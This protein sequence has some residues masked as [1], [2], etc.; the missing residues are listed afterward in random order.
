MQKIQYFQDFIYELCQYWIKQGCIWSQPYDMPMGAGTFHPHTFFKSLGAEPWR[1]VYVQPC[2]RPV[3]G[4]YGKSPNRLQHYYQLQVLIKPAPANILDIYLKSLEHIGINLKQNDIALYEDNWKGPT[5]GAWGLGWEVRANG[6]EVTQFTYFQEFAGLEMNMIPCEITYGLERIFMYANGHRN[7]MDIPYNKHFTYGDIFLQNEFEFSKFNFQCADTQLLFK[8]FDSFEEK[9]AELCEKKLS[10]PAYDYVLQASHV[11]NLLDARGALSVTERQRFIGRVRDGAKQCAL[12]YSNEQKET[13][14]RYKNPQWVTEA[15]PTTVKDVRKDK[16][17]SKKMDSIVDILLEIGVEE[18]PPDFQISAMKSLTH[19]INEGTVKFSETYAY[20]DAFVAK[21]KAMKIEVLISARRIAFLCRNIPENTPKQT[22]ELWGPAESIAKDSNG[23]LTP[24][25][26]GFCKKNNLEPG[27][28]QYREKKS[29]QNGP[30][31][32]FLYAEKVIN[33]CNF[34]KILLNEFKTYLYSLDAPLKMRWL[35]DVN[36]QQFVRPVRW[37]LCLVDD[38]VYPIEMFGLRAGNMT[39]GQRV[40]DPN[41]IEIRHIS[42]YQEKLKKSS[43]F[44]CRKTR[45]Q[46]IL[47]Q[48]ED[49]IKKLGGEAKLA[50]D[51]DLLEKCVGMTE[52]PHV[53][54]GHFYP[55][56]LKLPQKLVTSVLK[57]HMNYFSI[58]DTSTNKLMPCYIGVANYKCHDLKSMMKGSQKVITSRLEDGAFY[59]DGDLNTDFQS[60]REKLKAQVFQENLGTVFDKTE[61]LA[62]F[63]KSLGSLLNQKKLNNLSAKDIDYLMDA[64][65]HCKN[66]LKT[67]CVQEFP[68]EMQGVMGGVLVRKQNAFGD[69]SKSEYI[70]RAIEEHYFPINATAPLPS[71]KCGRI[72]SLVDKFDSM[73][74]LLSAGFEPKGNQDPFGLRRL[75]IAIARLLFQKDNAFKFRCSFDE[76]LHVWQSEFPFEA[77]VDADLIKNF[78]KDRVKNLLKEKFNTNSVESVLN[79]L[80]KK[81]LTIFPKLL[82][83]LEKFVQNT[84]ALI[85][86]KRAKSMTDKIKD[87]EINSD[88]FILEEEKNLYTLYQSVRKNSTQ[89]FEKQDFD[90]FFAELS[91]LTKPLGHFFDSV[92]V[93]DPNLIVRQ[94]RLQ[95]LFKIRRLYEDT[96]DFSVVQVLTNN[97]KF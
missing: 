58:V 88:L 23:S 24:A 2:R 87:E 97:E 72:L 1:S 59:F 65:K 47:E 25:G 40:L 85:P 70:A 34:P 84:D 17:R 71:K 44:V 78:F 32:V 77:K 38:K 31:T 94:N 3:D 52:S 46:M 33:S 6:E 30:S 64:A 89:Y 15:Q 91:S 20:D 73:V 57:E 19:K 12:V 26:L 61:R 5:L 11:F 41:R 96:I 69:S 9:I 90:S 22:L 55:K 68:D 49:I 37:I 36:S 53:F 21:I 35:N 45:K 39:Y 48:S 83:A 42:K 92:L 60:L 95:L 56:Y 63:I 14:Q 51:I 80:T 66:D 28:I 13:N 79:L 76:I 93:N 74:L 50:D 16:K 54:L 86:Y 29:K 82:T 75:A 8:Q 18:M 4:R 67:G 7:I 81:P 10:L 43:V 62:Q 27:N